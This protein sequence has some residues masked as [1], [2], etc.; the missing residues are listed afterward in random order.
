LTDISIFLKV[1]SGLAH[2]PNRSPINRLA[3]ARTNES[4]IHRGTNV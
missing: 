3:Q 1:A 2:H 4:V